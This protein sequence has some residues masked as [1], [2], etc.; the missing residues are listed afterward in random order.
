MRWGGFIQETVLA[1]IKHRITA[2]EFH[3]NFFSFLFKELFNNTA[4]RDFAIFHFL[5]EKDYSLS[6]KLTKAKSSGSCQKVPITL[7]VL[8]KQSQVS[9]SVTWR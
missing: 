3:K 9:R 8:W 1:E 5:N 6:D 4:I 7:R 2:L